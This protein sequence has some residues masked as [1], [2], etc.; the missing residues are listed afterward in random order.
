MAAANSKIVYV[1]CRANVNRSFIVEQLLQK[2]VRENNL[3]VVVTSG[4]LQA[5]P[6][7][8]N[9]LAYTAQVPQFVQALQRLGLDFIIP[10][11]EQHRAHNFSGSELKRAD[12][13]LTMTLRQRDYLSQHTKPTTQVMML[14]Q[15][16]D[17]TREIDVFD[18]MEAPVSSYEAFVY[19]IA[20]LQYYLD[21][22][23]F[24]F[25]LGLG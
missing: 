13:I 14:S 12:L 3:P 6:Q 2:F 20:Q 15:L 9:M 22:Q 25:R 1:G 21:Y 19:E 4:G 16:A 11:I 7:A 17:L 8:P 18:A 24:R 5:H 23:A 10:N